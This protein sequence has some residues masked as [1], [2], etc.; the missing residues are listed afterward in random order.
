MFSDNVVYTNTPAVSLQC[1]GSRGSLCRL[2]CEG[3]ERI[4]HA[5]CVSHALSLAVCVGRTMLRGARV[6]T[7]TFARL[8]SARAVA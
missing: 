2:C 3:Q 6:S 4:A 5:A 1:R 7:H 8:S